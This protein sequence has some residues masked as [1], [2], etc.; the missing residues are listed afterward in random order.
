MSLIAGS[1]QAG[2]WDRLK[3]VF[4]QE[5]KE[6]PQTIK[7]LLYH[8]TPSAT[9]E[10][11]GSYNIYDPFKNKRIATRFA[12]KGSR[13]EALSTGL[14][15]GEEFVGI[16][17]IK[18]I[19]DSLDIVTT[20]NGQDFRGSIYVYDIGGSVSIVNELPIEDYLASVMPS[21]YQSSYSEE[22]IAA[23]T[24]IER[25]NA[26]NLSLRSDNSYWHVKASEQGYVGVKNEGV[27]PVI[28]EA[29]GSTRYMVLSKTGVYEGTVTPF[30]VSLTGSSARITVDAIETLSKRGN[31]AAQI[32][33]KSFPE[34]RVEL[35]MGGPKAK[36]APVAELSK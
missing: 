8:D 1:L 21:K 34:A 23:A 33:T 5:A 17:Q 16:Y 30:A 9:L 3:N 31:N 7:V 26:F 29:L 15:W 20:I 19:P 27:N 14:K 25:T 28:T 13:I 35:M 10:V 6:E 32:L 24:I 36:E 4:V 18:I 12:P 22:T 11:K 2:V